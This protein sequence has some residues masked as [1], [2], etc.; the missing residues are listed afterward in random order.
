MTDAYPISDISA[1]QASDTYKPTKETIADGSS[2]REGGCRREPYL[3]CRSFLADLNS[4][5]LLN[6][7]PCL[8]LGVPIFCAFLGLSIFLEAYVISTTAHLATFVVGSYV[9]FSSYFVANRQLLASQQRAAHA[10]ARTQLDH[11]LFSLARANRR[12][13]E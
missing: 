3:A 5:D 8:A 2:E 12:L 9:V 4:A 11:H 13:H 7:G 10:V 6:N 1:P